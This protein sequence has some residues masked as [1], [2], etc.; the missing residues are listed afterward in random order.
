MSTQVKRLL[1][2]PERLK[3]V[4]GMPFNPAIIN[5]LDAVSVDIMNYPESRKIPGL[6]AF[7][8]W[9]RKKH[10]LQFE[11]RY[12]MDGRCGKGFIFHICASNIP[13][14]F[15]WSM[16]IGLLMGNSNLVRVSSR[17]ESVEI[18]EVF[19]DV[20][21]RVLK[22]EAYK[23]LADRVAIITYP[24]ENEQLTLRYS[25]QCNIRMVWGGDAAIE[26]ISHLKCDP[27]PVDIF[28]P[29]R[30]S[31]AFLD[32]E[33]VNQLS[34]DELD[35]Q[36]QLFYDDTYAMDQNACSSPQLIVWR[37]E[38]E[39]CKSASLRWWQAVDT[40][41]AD[42]KISEKQI[43]DKYSLACETAMSEACENVH[44][45]N[46]KLCHIWLNTL[47]KEWGN[48]KGNSGIFL[49]Y[50]VAT[51][52]DILKID[53]EKLQT[54]LVLGI[55]RETLKKV[56]REKQIKGISRIVP[57]GQALEMDFVWDGKDLTQC[58]TE[59]DF[60]QWQ[61]KYEDHIMMIDDR[62]HQMTYREAKIFG[63][64]YFEGV[65]RRTLMLLIKENSI[66]SVLMYIHALRHDL[67]PMLLDKKIDREQLRIITHQ[68][69][70]EYAAVPETFDWHFGEDY[71]ERWHLKG[72]IF[73]ERVSQEKEDI[74]IHPNLTLLLSTSGSTGS[75]KF[76][77]I[78]KVNLQSNTQSIARYLKITEND[79][80]ITTLPMSYTYGLSIINSHFYV[81]ATLLLT[82]CSIME[83]AFW[84]FFKKQMAT[85][86][87]GVPY[88]YKML[89]YIGFLEMSLPS[90]KM[91]T[92]AGGK[93]SVN[94]QE[95]FTAYGQKYGR[96]LI[97]MYG[98]TEATARMAYLP[99]ENADQK[100]GSI[101]KAIPGGRFLLEDVAGDVITDTRKTG[102]LIYVG[103]NVTMG[104][105]INRES[106][107]AGDENHGWLATGDLAYRDEDGFYYI[108]GRKKR[109]I[110]LLGNRISLDE[111]EGLLTQA[112]PELEFVC[113]GTDADEQM[114][115]FY[116][117]EIEN[118]N[119][120]IDFLSEKLHLFRKNFTVYNIEKIPR[121]SA[122][123][124]Q[125]QLL[126][127]IRKK[128]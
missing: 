98:Q 29:D 28:F 115:V 86:F 59:P 99:W 9:C 56:I 53:N 70:P 47:T 94:L 89:K 72:Y 43:Y 103:Q 116:T 118:E 91:M 3:L 112:F 81:G 4:K 39:A 75:P 74:S 44:W 16:A 34:K 33:T 64:K 1:G 125:Y 121:N 50:R 90:L 100:Q 69:R 46:Q 73:Y 105:A 17:K 36:A 87:G 92:Q 6:R 65:K 111:T 45:V 80:P 58:L 107:M 51:E 25:E 95:I 117:G 127:E 27:E 2:N 88:T 7:G 13:G 57:L 60:F 30:V 63:Q 68:Y 77:K 84:D 20:F 123:K 83:Q 11:S 66:G 23:N 110:K 109:F 21:D 124:T 52:E 128:E 35:F 101:G 126:E 79:R 31:A 97:V 67:V 93:L 42:Y 12:Q 62:N 8:F 113:T 38:K 76:V 19:C 48:F 15:A 54:L 18:A 55:E 108:A 102:E 24:K 41:L 106:L 120:I 104:Y 14:L 49:E 85:T 119:K 61:K 96:P 40:Q 22:K 10:L 5:F 82:E 37:G 122:G 32:A 78:S 114:A 26:A 71:R